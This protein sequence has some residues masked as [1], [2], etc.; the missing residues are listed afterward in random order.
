MDLRGGC[1][2]ENGQIL[3]GEVAACRDFFVHVGSFFVRF[4]GSLFVLFFVRFLNRFGGAF[5]R[6]FGAMLASV[7]D[8]FFVAISC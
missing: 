4:F 7:F 5:G 8:V 2:G 6:H 1:R 3:P